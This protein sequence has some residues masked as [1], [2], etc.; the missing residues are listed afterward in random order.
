MCQTHCQLSGGCPQK[1]HVSKLPSVPSSST[2]T[3][4]NDSLI[5]P[6]L[7]THPSSMPQPIPIPLP[8]MLPVFTKQQAALQHADAD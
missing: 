2:S 1:D 4:V 6:S 5:D 3:T 7:H 8:A